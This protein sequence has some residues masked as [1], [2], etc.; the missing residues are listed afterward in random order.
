MTAK[1]GKIGE[2]IERPGRWRWVNL[3]GQRVQKQNFLREGLLGVEKGIT[4]YGVRE[5]KKIARLEEF[6]FSYYRPTL[7]VEPPSFHARGRIKIREIERLGDLFWEIQS[8][9]S[10]LIADVSATRKGMFYM[11]PG[12][13]GHIID[14]AL[15][16]SFPAGRWME[17]KTY[18]IG[19]PL[20]F[21]GEGNSCHFDLNIP[22]PAEVFPILPSRL[23]FALG[24]AYVNLE[25]E[26]EQG[27]YLTT[28]FRFKPIA[29]FPSFP[30]RNLRRIKNLSA[31]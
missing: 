26:N 18:D 2:V 4:W 25:Y 14:A 13:S 16:L 8:Y 12:V 7:P 1:I 30:L 24:M 6:H 9:P 5:A 17:R 19:T 21:S 10:L 29:E 3:A 11:E 23:D 15:L 31:D 22:A 20:D 27:L 28:A